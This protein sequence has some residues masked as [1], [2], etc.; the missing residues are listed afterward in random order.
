MSYSE[1]DYEYVEELD[2]H[3]HKQILEDLGRPCRSCK[4]L[5][6]DCP[7]KEEVYCER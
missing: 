5:P 2:Q 4:L 7:E 1:R 3:I 6:C